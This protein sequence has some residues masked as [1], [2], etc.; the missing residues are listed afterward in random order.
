[1]IE[2]KEILRETHYGLHIYTQIMCEKYPLDL[3]VLELSGSQ[4]RLARNPFNDD[5][6]TLNISKVDDVF[7]YQDTEIPSFKG[8]P[9]DFAAL[10][11]QLNGQELLQKI[12]DDLYLH[13][14]EQKGF[15]SNTTGT[16]PV[17]ETVQLP[18]VSFF[19]SPI[20]NTRPNAEMSIL[21][22]YEAVKGNRY[23][24]V[25]SELRNCSDPESARKYKASHLD[26]VTFGGVFSK[27][28]D[29]CL[30]QL[31]G[32][33]CFDFDHVNNLQEVK[34]TLIADPHFDTSL[35]F[36]SPSGNGI[37]WVIPYDV[38]DYS[39]DQWFPSVSA[40]LHYTY[41]LEVD[42][43]G[44]DLSRACFLCHDPDVYIN[45][46]FIAIPRINPDNYREDTTDGRSIVLSNWV[47]D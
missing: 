35:L 34:E 22:V 8:N 28:S 26:Y 16:L 13:I 5:H 2:E 47:K 37:K 45:P 3:S 32:C 25:T 38:E 40:Y 23:K 29:A 14:G 17:V 15:Y 6:L 42:R 21:D 39:Y 46:E 9:F 30:I 33:L 24:H 1:M 12:N 10:Y 19:R 11:Y 4:C 31:S 20:T 27:R 41:K 36:Y 43:S 44:K 7:T 18:K